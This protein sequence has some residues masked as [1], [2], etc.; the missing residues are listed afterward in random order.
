MG[1]GEEAFE[2]RSRLW[3]SNRSGHPV[4]LNSLKRAFGG[5]K[6][7]PRVRATLT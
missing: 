6:A 7:D 3:S 5:C 2:K 4:L 1:E